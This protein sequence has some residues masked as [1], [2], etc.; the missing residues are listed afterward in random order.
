MNI[1]LLEAKAQALRETSKV[2]RAAITM[3]EESAKQAEQAANEARAL[4][5]AGFWEYADF[6]IEK[7]C[8][9][10]EA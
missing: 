10:L 6:E 9:E 3:L 1:E 2:L 8:A 5:D 4:L 7:A